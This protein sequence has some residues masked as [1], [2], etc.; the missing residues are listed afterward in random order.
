MQ[1]KVSEAFNRDQSNHLNQHIAALELA[2][3][4]RQS[5][6]T[7]KIINQI[8]GDDNKADPAKVRMMDG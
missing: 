4:R 7:W 3:Q 8:A 6:T 2:D 5:G 1:G